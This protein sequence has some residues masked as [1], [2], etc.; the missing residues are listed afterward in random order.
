MGL[1]L[2]IRLGSV[3]LAGF[4]A[5]MVLAL[6]AGPADAA[7]KKR[8]KARKKRVA[9]K[10]LVL[11]SSSM[12]GAFGD[13]ISRGL[14]RRGYTT[15]KQG[16]S[17]TGFARPDYF[18]WQAEIAKLPIQGKVAGAVIYLGTNDAQAIHLRPSERRR[19]R[20]KGRWLRWQDRR[21]TKVYARRVG[22]FAR[23]LCARGV[24]RVAL[25][26]PV[27][28]VKPFLRERLRQVRTAIA[29]GAKP[30]PCARAFSGRGD[31]RR[32]LREAR[33]RKVARAKKKLRA[34]KRSRSKKKR[35]KRRPRLRQ[36]DGT[37]LTRAGARAAWNRVDRRID[38]WFRRGPVP[39]KR[40]RKKRRLRRKRRVRA[41]KRS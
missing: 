22:A 16:N 30:V 1:R 37:H 31:V 27:S 33:A 7:R 32:I 41:S 29:R 28:V 23:A 17:S 9:G 6:V 11:G 5:M 26:T 20:H 38:R 25:L 36:P 13:E 3:L 39:K 8:R 15:W 2:C 10:V 19:L 12:N 14:K 35:T 40:A 24:H 21:W 34:R 4:V 18:D